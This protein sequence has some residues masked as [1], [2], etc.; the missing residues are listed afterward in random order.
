MSEN[1]NEDLQKFEEIQAML[2]GEEKGMHDDEKGAHEDEKGAPSVFMTDI[3]F[4]EMQDAGELISEEAF[5][6]LS[7]EDQLLMEK[8]LVMDEKGET[9]MGWMFRFKS[10]DDEEEAAEEE[11]AEEE[12]AEEEAAEEEA[13]E[14]EA[15]EEEADE[16]DDE[17]EE[18][19][20]AEEADEEEDDEDDDD[21][22]EKAAVIM[23]MMRKPKNDKPS[24]FLT[25]SRFK[26]MM[27]DGE[28]VSDEDFDGLDEDAKGAF[29]AVDVYE[30]GTGKGYGRR[31][32]RRSPLELNAMRK[33]ERENAVEDVFETA[34]E[35]MERAEA[36]GCEGMH[37]AGK[38]F[39]PCASHDEWMDLSKKEMAAKKE[40]EAAQAEAAREAR[41]AAQAAQQQ[42]Q[43]AAPAGM[44]AEG[45]KSDDFLCGFSRKSVNQPCEFCQGGCMPTE[46]L[47]GL[48]DI[49][50]QV[51]SLHEGSEVVG[52]GYSTADDIF[53][54]D[55]KRADGSCIQVFLSGE[56][57]EMGW[58]RIDEDEMDAKSGEM[59]DIVSQADA[60]DAAVKALEDL[61]IKGDVM[62]VLVDVFANQDVYVVEVDTDEKSYDVF[63]SPEGKVLGFD[64]Y[65]VENPFD[66]DMDEE[67]EL[68]ALEAEL[69]IKRMY[70]REQREAMAESGDALPD[71]S[72]PIADAADLDNAIQAYGRAKDKAAAKEH[73]MKRAKELGKEDM[74]PA[75]WN[76]EEPEAPE[77]EADAPAEKEEDV[78]LINALAEF[79]NMLDGEDLA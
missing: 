63:V 22:S 61:D 2:D 31:Y 10:E 14:E 72:F 20:D 76:E 9:P 44:P 19:D 29:E 60:E 16:A 38:M 71:G 5:A 26:E 50:S 49:E 78:E 59:Q 36:L 66:Y 12:A 46:N 70:S 62:G 21:V 57:E 48:G 37:R 8:V 68:K 15:D 23:S 28:L 18:D 74:I 13:A 7:E 73:I 42:A 32:R 24:I 79:Q 75:D 35:A 25:D 47:P 11:A 52:S 58:L 27:E 1:L 64:E 65:E 53:V 6:E 55:V 56:G 45:M 77:A 43:G 39:M 17:A 51:K 40:R 33:A 3:R 69:E 41:Q 4:E 67:D 54:V 30:E 34:E